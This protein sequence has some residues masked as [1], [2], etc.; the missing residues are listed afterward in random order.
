M[1]IRRFA[2]LFCF[3]CVCAFLEAAPALRGVYTYT[4]P[5]GT[6]FKA[7]LDGDE[8]SKKLTTL[9]GCYF[10]KGE[11]GYYHYAAFGADG[12]M[13]PSG[14]H[15]GD[16]APAKLLSASRVV[17]EAHLKLSGELSAARRGLYAS[18]RER[19]LQQT[20]PAKSGGE[21]NV[22][23]I[24]VV[25]A[26]FD[27][28]KFIHNQSSFENIFNEPGYNSTGSVSDY[29]K[30]Q[31]GK[32]L[33][34]E[35]VVGPV[36]T[37]SKDFE[38][39]GSNN[40]ENQDMHPE[41][42]IVEAC[43]LYE[44][45]G[46]DFSKFDCDG[47]GVVDN[48]VC[49]FAGPDESQG[50]SPEHIWAH[51]S[52]ISSSEKF[53]GKRLGD[54]TISAEL[55]G[56][57]TRLMGIGTVCHEISHTLGLMDTY[58][59]DDKNSGGRYIGMWRYLDIMDAGNYNNAGQTPPN[60]NSFE[61]KMVGVG[62]ESPMKFGEYTLKP[63]SEA[64]SEYLI[65][66]GTDKDEYFLFESRETKVW[67][68]YIGGSG[69]LVYHIDGSKNEAGYSSY[70]KK[71]LSAGERWIYN[72]VNANPAHPCAM[73]VSSTPISYV[74]DNVPLSEIP[75]AFFPYFSINELKATAVKDYAFWNS[76]SSMPTISNIVRNKI[77]GEVSFTVSGPITID[78]VNYFQDAVIVQ[79]TASSNGL[80]SEAA[81]IYGSDTLE[82]KKVR[83]YYRNENH[84]SV[85]FEG[86]TPNL[87]YRLAISIPVGAQRISVYQN[88][89]T[90]PLRKSV[91]PFI[92]LISVE[93]N[94][95]GS[96]VEGQELPLRVVNAVGA[97]EIKWFC[98]GA[99]IKVA[100]NGY[101]PARSGM[102]EAKIHYEDGSVDVIR[103]KLLVLPKR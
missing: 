73:L 30:T 87:S 103:K 67:D 97:K 53:S 17:P 96:I 28:L 51:M 20:A 33:E 90:L 100:E 26:Q 71:T 47:N 32:H 19:L 7:L 35:F 70:Y 56:T 60:Y 46:I 4:Q 42:L 16:P 24:L 55:Y 10:C 5:D 21:V 81:I 77:S 25:L 6:E 61:K 72:E 85:T 27:N 88:F 78:K 65:L 54:Y 40:S 9:D 79:W 44:S 84:Y 94:P 18:S 74:H 22:R 57:G 48:I 31:L 1:M 69:L 80:E 75:K 76:D 36:V 59:T 23:K 58:D 3:I 98:N 86:L 52:R 68:R 101:W 12:R 45:Q 64:D 11:D 83:P 50:A 92:N 99:P 14:Y 13:V 29:F 2:A 95:D 63:L 89:T 62:K 91:Y 38:Y 34:F 93:R 102:L 8:F 37:V 43:R 66:Q 41:E 39:Y 49:I 82:C 15:V